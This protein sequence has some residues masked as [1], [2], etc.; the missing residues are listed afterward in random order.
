MQFQHRCGNMI[1]LDEANLLVREMDRDNDG[2]VT[3]DDF[4]AAKRG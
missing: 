4:I 1:T 3:L 2:Q